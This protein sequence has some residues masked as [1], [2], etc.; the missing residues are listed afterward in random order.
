M[1][2]RV[3]TEREIEFVK[4]NIKYLT[5][6]EG[7]R[8]FSE[9]FG[10]KISARSWRYQRL[11]LGYARTTGWNAHLVEKNI[12]RGKSTNNETEHPTS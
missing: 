9:L 5:D 12:S 3:W 4:K 1:G 8:Q 6:E 11:L 7:A 10:R 2:K